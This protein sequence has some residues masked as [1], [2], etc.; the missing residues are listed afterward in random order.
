MCPSCRLFGMVEERD[1][2]EKSASTTQRARVAAYK[3]HV[4]FSH[5]TI[6]A[7]AM[8]TDP[9]ASK[10]D[11]LREFGA[12]RPSAGQFYL[13]NQGWEGQSAQWRQDGKSDRPLREWGSKADQ[14][15][16]PRPI[17]GRKQYWISTESRHP[18]GAKAH[19]QMSKFHRLA[20]LGTTLSFDV[21]FD[22]VSSAQLGSLLVALN[23][24]LLRYDEFRDELSHR[25]GATVAVALEQSLGHQVGKGKGVGLG[26]VEP[27]ILEDEAGGLSIWGAEIHGR[28]CARRT[29]RRPGNSHPRL[30]PGRPSRAVGAPARD[31]GHRLGAAWL[32]GVPA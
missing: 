12:P 22:N 2:E 14:G 10:P 11:Q 21:W 19:D 5:A 6:E 1:A 27:E 13:D 25:G 31:E 8:D 23:P 24:N 9:I 29:I 3:G 16:D 30:P 26:A 18:A 7:G 20:S 28:G 4:R 32:A 15:Q 17:R